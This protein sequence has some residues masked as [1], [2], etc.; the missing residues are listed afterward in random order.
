MPVKPIQITF[1]GLAHSGALDQEIREHVAW[2]EQFYAPITGCRVLVSLPHRHRRDARHF[3][4][5][6]ELTVPG[7]GSIVIAQEPSRHAALKDVA[8]EAH[9]KES[10]IESAH[11][12]ARVAIH[13]AF[14][15]ARRRLQ[16]FAR[17]QRGAVKAREQRA[18]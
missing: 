17:E 7:H 18:G 13:E 5:A 2:L 9:R 3:H 14:D 6:I 8:A 12:H 4:I 10:E 11:R 16:D 15:A 1:R